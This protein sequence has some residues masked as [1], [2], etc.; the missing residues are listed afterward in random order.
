M[1]TKATSPR[2][3]LFLALSILL[4]STSV[5]HAQERA[6]L[7]IIPRVDVHAH[8]GGDMHLTEGYL[9]IASILKDKYD[10]LLDMGYALK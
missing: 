4:A 3:A 6:R 8:I 10:V 7:S 1:A 5:P 2:L 9:K